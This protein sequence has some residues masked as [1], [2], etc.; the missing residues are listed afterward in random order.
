MGRA[1]KLNKRWLMLFAVAFYTLDLLLGFVYLVKEQFTVDQVLDIALLF[2][3]MALINF[4]PIKV[5]EHFVV[6]ANTISLTAFLHFG[7]WVEVILTQLA[8]LTTWWR[9]RIT[10]WE[11]L[12]G[13]LVLLLVTSFSAAGI[14]YLLGGRT[15]LL[16]PAT[17]TPLILPVLGYMLVIYLFNY[18]HPYILKWLLEDIPPRRMG[19]IW[20]ETM[21]LLILLPIGVL[22]SILFAQNGRWAF[23]YVL[24]PVLALS[25]TLMLFYRLKEINHKLHVIH[26][27]GHG[28]AAQLDMGMVIDRL[29]EGVGRLVPYHYCYLLL[30]DFDKKVLK[31][32]RLVGERILP[33]EYQRFMQTE[34]AF[35]ERPSCRTK[36][37][38]EIY[39]RHFEDRFS[40]LRQ[41]KSVCSVP[42]VYDQRLY[43]ILTLTHKQANQY[44]KADVTLVEI[45]A[46]QAAIA[47][48]N[49][50]D[51][52]QTRQQSERDELT[53]LYNYRYFKRRV[54]EMIASSSTPPFALILLDIDYFKKV[55]DLYGHLAGNTILKEIATIIKE[56]VKDRGT[57]AR[58][59]GEEF[60]ILL[61]NVT[62]EEAYLWADRLRGKIAATPIRLRSDLGTEGERE[63]IH[64]VSVSMG[65]ALYPI[66]AQDALNLT[67]Q[68]DRA[69]YMGAKRKGRNKVAVYSNL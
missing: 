59:G 11:W 57:V 35:D 67:R 16:L 5:K 68:A 65:I 53:G 51:Y 21:P 63:Y 10:S 4:F 31:P 32:V 14:F 50:F 8:M 62:E 43:G 60:V 27:L 33:E 25:I 9:Y 36:Q 40:F 44:I 64:Y 49:A 15:G 39:V 46:N 1:V 34:V 7:F 69:M 22:I 66:H 17:Y 61:E 20:R 41:Q 56:E 37:A 42:L 55:N 58:F 52:E 30:A 28:I 13:Q 2:T 24:F 23:F 3:L 18:L 12:F 38:D 47:F 45:L 48:K 54:E 6:L 26:K 19:N 29:L